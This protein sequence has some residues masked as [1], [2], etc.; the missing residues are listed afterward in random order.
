MRVAASEPLSEISGV[1][2]SDGT[3]PKWGTLPIE[4]IPFHIVFL[5]RPNSTLVTFFSRGSSLID[6]D[7][8]GLIAA[9]LSEASESD[10][11][12]QPDKSPDE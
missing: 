5:I 4:V 3:N 2:R 10:G 9:L 1:F 12:C 11:G 8:E 6:D 7:G